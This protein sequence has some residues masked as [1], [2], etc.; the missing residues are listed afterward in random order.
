MYPST[1]IILRSVLINSR[2]KSLCLIN[3]LVL[4]ATVLAAGRASLAA[5]MMA[6]VCVDLKRCLPVSNTAA[7]IPSPDQPATLAG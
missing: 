2:L 7:I 5:Y 3:G 6:V 4:T 1:A